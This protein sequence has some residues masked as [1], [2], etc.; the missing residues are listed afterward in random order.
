M[1]VVIALILGFVMGWAYRQSQI[2][3]QLGGPDNIREFL[4]LQKLLL[5]DPIC[6]PRIEALMQE[7][8]IELKTPR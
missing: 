5:V 6:K 7:H 2:V 8:Q 3:D 4:R 1:F